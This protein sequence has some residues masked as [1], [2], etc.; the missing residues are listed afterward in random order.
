VGCSKVIEVKIREALSV[1]DVMRVCV[2][3]EVSRERFRF[4]MARC[5]GS[6]PWTWKGIRGGE[7]M[8]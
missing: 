7:P 3:W 8:I 4:F 1:R 2:L 6:P 5:G